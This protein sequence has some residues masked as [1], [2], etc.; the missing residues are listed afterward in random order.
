MDGLPSTHTCAPADSGPRTFA[1]APSAI[2][3]SGITAPGATRLPAPIRVRAPIRAPSW[4][5]EPLP[6]SASAPITAPW[7]TQRCPI[8]APGPT[9]VSGSSPPCSTELSWMLAPARTRIRPKSARRTAPYQIEARASITTSPTT[10]A[11]GAIQASGWT[12]GERPSKE[13]SGM[14]GPYGRAGSELADLVLHR[15]EG[16]AGGDE[17]RVPHRRER[18]GVG[19][20]Q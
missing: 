4:T 11:V 2:T 16:L 18:R 10:V 8:V 14:P 13:N 7:T 6:I 5:V 15:L 3:S 12:C 17:D 19:E 1:G 9:S 20:V